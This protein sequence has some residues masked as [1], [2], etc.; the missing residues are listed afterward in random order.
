MIYLTIYNITHKKNINQVN[1]NQNLDISIKNIAFLSIKVYN[2]LRASYFK[3][4][5]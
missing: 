2:K 5:F 4:T 1:F 3:K